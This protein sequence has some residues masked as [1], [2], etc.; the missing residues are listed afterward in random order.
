LPV[1]QF[2]SK[3]FKPVKLLLIAF[4]LFSSC[5]KEL[6]KN[7]MPENILPEKLTP[8]TNFTDNTYREGEIVLGKKLENPYTIENMQK[9]YDNLLAKSN[10]AGKLNL[11]TLEIKTTHLYIRWLPKTWVEYDELKNDKKL[12]LYD[13]PLD[14]EVK[15]NGNKYHDKSIPENLPTWQYTVI[16]KDYKFNKKLKYE[17]LADAYIPEKDTEL[18]KKGG[19][20]AAGFSSDELINEAL[21][22]THNSEYLIPL[23]SKKGRVSDWR[24]AGRVTAKDTRLEA[25]NI[26]SNLPI[27]SQLVPI[28]GIQ[29][30]YVRARRFL[31]IESGVTNAEGYYTA[32]GTFGGSANYALYWEAPDF[33]VRSGGLGQAWVNGPFLSSDWNPS[34][35]DGED[36]FYAHVFRGAW[37]YHYGNIDMFCRPGRVPSF[38]FPGI[39]NSAIK[40][41]AYNSAGNNNGNNIGNWSFW[42]S[43]P[44]ISIW[45]FSSG[46]SEYLSDQIFATTTHETAHSTHM[47]VTNVNTF[48]NTSKKVRE[49]WAVFVEWYITQKE[50]RE[51]GI[52][53]YANIDYVV[54]AG[55]PID[56]AFQNYYLGITDPEYSSVFIDIFDNVNQNSIN[57]TYII[58]NVSG[59]TIENLERNILKYSFGITSLGETLKSNMPVNVNEFQIN[60]LIYQF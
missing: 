31:S 39:T 33:D 41:A 24:P 6:D 18:Q 30:V 20:M 43:N 45:R 36:R 55:G 54:N 4:V 53:N 27:P 32:G 2:A 52:S 12:L 59:Y 58:D 16:E 23:N 8:A 17:I 56:Y 22:I 44:N 19:R 25:H 46:S 14:Y 13:I 47:R 57:P 9:A 29:G 7:V 35:L 34:F 21:T 51:R 10:K 50:Y 48:L 40:Y 26:S 28:I 38:P 3:F 1:C 42:G 49:S 15:V 60:Q 37:R 5:K 11:G